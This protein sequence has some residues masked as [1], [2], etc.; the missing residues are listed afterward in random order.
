[1]KA[2]GGQRCS[3]ETSETNVLLL[4]GVHVGEVTVA[5]MVE[6]MSD[7]T[8]HCNCVEIMQQVFKGVIK[9]IC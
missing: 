9:W 2:R 5:G 6:A 1:M 8:N 3:H 7:T 4:F